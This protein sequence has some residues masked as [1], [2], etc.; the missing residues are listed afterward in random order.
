[1]HRSFCIIIGFVSSFSFFAQYKNIPI[2]C[3]GVNPVEPSVAINPI[4]TQQV[5]MG[6]VLSDYSYSNDGGQTWIPHSLK[7]PYGVYGDPVLTFD[8]KGRIYYFH[9]SDYER[10]SW[11]DRI[12]CQSTDDFTDPSSFSPGSFPKPNGTKAQDKHWVDIDPITGI[13]Y[14][15]W[16]Q[17]DK[18]DS[19]IPTDSSRIMFS[20]SSDRGESWTHPRVISFY[21]GDCLDG[22]KTVEGAVPV[23]SK[24]GELCVTWTGPKGLVIQ[25]S[26]DGGETWLQ[27]ERILKPQVGGWDFKIPGLY[28]CNGLPVLQIDRSGGPYDG[29]LYLSWGDQ[30]NGKEDTDI[31]L[32]KSVNGGKDWS[33]AIRVNQDQSVSHQ[34]MSTFTVDQANGNLHFLFY[35]R[36]TLK[37]A[38]E[39][40]VAWANST[41]GG[42]HFDQ[43]IISEKPF[44]PLSKVFFGDYIAISAY[45][46]KI[47]PVWVR[48]DMGKTSL[49]TADLSRP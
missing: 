31:W 3:F 38:N 39:T 22:D 42:D 15:T 18:Y 34:F 28:R 7:S 24:N 10:G 46:G 20:K 29:T 4:N 30:K 45:N 32:M 8:S 21:N 12:V 35:D 5:A 25:E 23:V 2:P 33:E 9:L 47:V 43:K 14:M 48:M 37:K 17:F 1:M 11:I 27:K 41:D 13:I 40:H 26:K 19:K 44:V 6:A 49:W 36:S 16:T